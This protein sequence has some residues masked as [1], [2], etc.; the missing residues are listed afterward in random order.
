[1]LIVVRRSNARSARSIGFKPIVSKCAD[2]GSPADGGVYAGGASLSRWTSTSSVV[3]GAGLLH[4]PDDA[5]VGRGQ[6]CDAVAMATAAGAP[7]GEAVASVAAT[8][9]LLRPS[10]PRPSATG[11]RGTTR[12]PSSAEQSAHPTPRCCS[13]PAAVVTTAAIG[14]VLRDKRNRQLGRVPH[15]CMGDISV[16]RSQA[17]VG[18]HGPQAPA[19]AIASA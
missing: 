17:S 4:P 11:R 18:L 2:C 9:C 3:G 1:M 5:E 19:A 14:R 15:D 16:V 12:R 7:S 13:R 6:D 10:A 8:S